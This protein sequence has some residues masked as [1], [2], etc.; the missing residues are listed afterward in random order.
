MYVAL[1]SPVRF[2]SEPP[3]LVSVSPKVVTVPPMVVTVSPRFVTV[4]PRVVTVLPMLVTVS[5]MVVTLSPTRCTSWFVSCSCAPFTAS[6][7]VAVTAPRARLVSLVPPVMP[8]SVDADPASVIRLL[9]S[10]A[11]PS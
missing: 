6:V 10:P 2:A 11:L 3:R 7:L 4:S 8:P 9:G 5:P 1:V